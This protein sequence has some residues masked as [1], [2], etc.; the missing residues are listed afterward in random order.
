MQQNSL[1]LE[2]RSESTPTALCAQLKTTAVD[3]AFLV[4][5][6]VKED[7]RPRFI[8][9]MFSK[10]QSID[11]QREGWGCL[12]TSRIEEMISGKCRH[13]SSSTRIR[14]PL[15]HPILDAANS[16]SERRL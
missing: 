16:A 15:R 8:S 9:E 1:Q 14:P 13:H 4:V 5:T 11:L 7:L 3:K 12:P 10:A 6:A 2:E